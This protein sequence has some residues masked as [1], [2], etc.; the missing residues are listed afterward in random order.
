MRR[1]AEVS[2]VGSV[3]A[4]FLPEFDFDPDK[5]KEFLD[6]RGY[7]DD[8]RYLFTMEFEDIVPLIDEAAKIGYLKFRMEVGK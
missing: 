7:E 4:A 8:A 5:F 1:L 3:P 6:Q 2:A